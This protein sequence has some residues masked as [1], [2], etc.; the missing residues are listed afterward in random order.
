MIIGLSGKLESG[1]STLA[2][3][4]QKH[5]SE[6]GVLITAF[7]RPLKDMCNSYFGFSHNDLYTTEG[8]IKYNEF[9][10]M[11][12][13]EFMQR[14]GQGLRDAI[15]KDVW[16]KLLK[17]SILEKKDIYK[18]IIVDDC[19]YPEELQMIR[20]LGGIT[21][22]II[23]PD[24]VAVSNGIKNHPSEQDIPDEMFDYE[25][26]NIGTPEDLY[27]NFHTLVTQI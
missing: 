20:D 2:K 4:I 1:K 13:R 10:G 23:R 25:F 5:H 16:V 8:K 7:A 3:E 24:H 22:R 21:I 18:I 11:T 14:L 27:N 17:N 6:G 15:G 9:W 26:A 19:R 12:P